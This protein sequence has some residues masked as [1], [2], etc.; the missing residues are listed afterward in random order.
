[1][2]L[3]RAVA[4]LAV[5]LVALGS[6][7]VALAA[8]ED[9]EK[10]VLTVGNVGKLD[11]PNVTVGYTVEA[12]ELWNLHYATLT[13]KAADDFATIPGLAE[14]WEGS[15]DGLTW[16]YTLREGLQWSDG[17]PL[18]A[19]DIAYTI[20]RARDEE[21]LNHFSTVENLTA[22]ATDDT[23]LVVTSKVPDP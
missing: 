15:D 22:E 5:V 21:W 23:T 2:N 11:S 9:G 18:T 16:T 17:E 6:V 20:N 14:S 19:E 4:A 1:M 12:Y 7:T 8:D 3:R 10:V 13:D